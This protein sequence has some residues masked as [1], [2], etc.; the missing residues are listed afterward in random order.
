M[1]VTKVEL[2][3]VEEEKGFGC[4]KS[5][6]TWVWDPASAHTVEVLSDLGTWGLYNEA[7]GT[8]FKFTDVTTSGMVLARTDAK[9]T[10]RLD[11]IERERELH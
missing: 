7:S 3:P 9:S 4:L 8:L 6:V 5:D 1:E 11:L 2:V 10:R